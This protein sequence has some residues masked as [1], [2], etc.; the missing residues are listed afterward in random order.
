MSISVNFLF[1]VQDAQIPTVIVAQVVTE[2]KIPLL[3]GSELDR[4]S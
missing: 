3:G 2:R 1:E 4:K